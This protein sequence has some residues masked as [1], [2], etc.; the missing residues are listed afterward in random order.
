MTARPPHSPGATSPHSPGSRDLE[1][2]RDAPDA[3]RTS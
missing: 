3:E 2:L 1:A